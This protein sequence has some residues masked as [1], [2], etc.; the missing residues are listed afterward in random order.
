MKTAMTEHEGREEALRTDALKWHARAEKLSEELATAFAE[1]SLHRDSV[2]TGI[3]RKRHDEIVAE[4]E[5]RI[6]C[7]SKEREALRKAY[8]DLRNEHEAY[9]ARW[10]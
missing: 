6:E 8:S 1:L 7:I 3:S 5:L 9:K 4:F 10:K 2:Y